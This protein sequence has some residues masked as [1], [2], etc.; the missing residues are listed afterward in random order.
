[1][2]ELKAE[3]FPASSQTKRRGQTQ[4]ENLRLTSSLTIQNVKYWLK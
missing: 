3:T 1:M 2:A 4:N